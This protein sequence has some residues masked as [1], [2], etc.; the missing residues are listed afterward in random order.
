[1][2]ACSTKAAAS[3]TK[4]PASAADRAGLERCRSLMKRS[5]NRPT[6]RLGRPPS[7]RASRV[8]GTK[9]RPI[10]SKVPEITRP[11]SKRREPAVVSVMSEIPPKLG[12]KFNHAV[13]RVSIAGRSIPAVAENNINDF[14]A[15]QENAR[16]R[17]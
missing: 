15:L 12:A 1:M 16:F 4:P 10:T 11:I 5:W 17:S 14:S 9:L 3:M 8:K 6:S 13:N 7:S 2:A